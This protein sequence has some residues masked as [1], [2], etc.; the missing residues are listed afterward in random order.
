MLAGSEDP[1]T[2]KPGSFDVCE[3]ARFS[4][5]VTLFLLQ[6]RMT[7]LKTA[8]APVLADTGEAG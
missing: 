5:E 3:I 8:L 4:V 1:F 6:S 7:T 2:V